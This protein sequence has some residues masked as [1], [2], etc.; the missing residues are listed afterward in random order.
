VKYILLCAVLFASCAAPPPGRIQGSVQ[1]EPSSE[2]GKRLSM[3]AEEDCA[4][5]HAEAVIE[6]RNRFA[7]VYIKAGLEAKNFEPTAT[8]VVIEQKGCMFIPR[9][10]GAMTGQTIAVK[11]SDPVSHSI[12]PMPR[13]NREWN[14]Q[15]TPGAPDLERKFAQPEFLIPVKCNIHAWMKAYI[16]VLPH[17]HFSALT[18]GGTFDFGELPPGEYTLAAWHEIHGEKTSQLKL[19]SGQASAVNFVFP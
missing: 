14:Q 9:V 7:F 19:A 15:Q 16:A 12:H 10:V 2:A 5:L 11:N 4:K 6:D 1:I 8:K 17:P 3:D 18:S 13:N